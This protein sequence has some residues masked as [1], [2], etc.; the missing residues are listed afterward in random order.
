M[1]DY[2]STTVS[3]HAN[4][5]IQF[6]YYSASFAGRRKNNQDSC[7]GLK[8]SKN[9]IFLA[10]ADG[11]G[12]VAGGEVASNL[13]IESARRVLKDRFSAE[14][15][16]EDLKSILKEIFSAAQTD[17]SNKIK[18]KPELTGMGTT[19]TCVLILDGKFVWGNMGDSRVY[20]Y[21]DSEIKQLSIDHTQIQ[22]Y[23][24]KIGPDIPERLVENHGHFLTRAINGGNYEPDIFPESEPYKLFNSGEAFLLCSDGLILNKSDQLNQNLTDY[25]IG[26]K[27]LKD[28]AENLI[29]YAYNEGSNDNITV[30]LC[31]NG[32]LERQRIKLKKYGYPPGEEK[33]NGLSFFKKWIS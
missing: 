4:L 21:S 31:S 9:S 26:T 24:D 15:W 11:M 13:V 18:E 1:K 19:L 8:P 28:A 16:P 14:I 10:V 32:K 30:V 20:L 5:I 29:S 23:I 6:D 2:V 7:L 27:K 25:L 17:I 3:V 12:G 33:K 22:E